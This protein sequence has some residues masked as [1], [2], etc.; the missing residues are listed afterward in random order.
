MLAEEKPKF[1]VESDLH[2]DSRTID[3]NEILL[4]PDI[5]IVRD[6][7]KTRKRDIDKPK[8]DEIEATVVEITNPSNETATTESTVVNPSINASNE[9]EAIVSTTT[10][11]DITTSIAPSTDSSTVSTIETTTI[12]NEPI[13]I[14]TS[15]SASNFQPAYGYFYGNSA[16]ENADYIYFT[17]TDS[18][19]QIPTSSD[20]S[21]PS[22][23][24]L[25]R[26]RHDSGSFNPSVQYE[27]QNYRYKVDDHF[28]PIVGQKQIF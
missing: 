4:N 23:S 1:S 14:K 16:N 7:R 25:I 22:K 26:D 6:D 8:G 11:Q 20:S 13:P 12:S 28:I 24:K 5:E 17:T 21:I 19:E 27:Y 15:T 10:E 18:I 2:P 9:H 3:A